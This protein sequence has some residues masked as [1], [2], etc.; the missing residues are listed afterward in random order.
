M[1]EEGTAL[2]RRVLRWWRGGRR[3]GRWGCGWGGGREEKSEKVAVKPAFAGEALMVAVYGADA[4]IHIK[5]KGRNQR[6]IWNIAQRRK[7]CAAVQRMS[8]G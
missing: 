5:T 6:W 2:G 3:G 8:T 4:E 7:D 1:K